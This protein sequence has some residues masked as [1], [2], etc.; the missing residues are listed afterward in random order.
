MRK[1][2]FTKKKQA[3]AAG[4]YLITKQAGYQ[5]SPMM[6]FTSHKLQANPGAH[7]T[8]ASFDKTVCEQRATVIP[9]CIDCLE[10]YENKCYDMS[11]T[12][13]SLKSGENKCSAKKHQ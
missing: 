7:I 12:L 11:G 13:H 3:Q 9:L 2:L 4:I 8:I 10:E 5:I 1:S 6:L